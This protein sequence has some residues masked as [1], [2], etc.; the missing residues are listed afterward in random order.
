MSD[1][2]IDLL[3]GVLCAAVPRAAGR[4]RPADRNMSFGHRLDPQRS[5]FRT[6]IHVDDAWK[7]SMAIR[8][9]SNRIVTREMLTH[10]YATITTRS[11]A[12]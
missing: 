3:Y 2:L 6:S 7:E 12:D 8:A 11:A 4:R 10:E 1:L 5:I 9:Y